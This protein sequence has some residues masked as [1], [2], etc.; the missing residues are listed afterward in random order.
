MDLG[1]H[2]AGGV[3]ALSWNQCPT[4]TEKQLYNYFFLYV[5]GFALLEFCS[6]F[7]ASIFTYSKKQLVMASILDFQKLLLN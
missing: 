6:G 5:A 4:H 2:G 1:I 3:G 7:F